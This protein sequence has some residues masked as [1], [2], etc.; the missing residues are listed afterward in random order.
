[1]ACVTE[2]VHGTEKTRLAFGNLHKNQPLQTLILMCTNLVERCIDGWHVF[3][4][5][6]DV[7]TRNGDVDVYC[8][9]FVG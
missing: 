1:M 5:N 2:F 3:V 8:Q 6:C 4:E 9:W 7:F